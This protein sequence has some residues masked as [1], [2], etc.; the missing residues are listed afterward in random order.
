MLLLYS[1]SYTYSPESPEFPSLVALQVDLSPPTVIGCQLGKGDHV[2]ESP[3]RTGAVCWFPYSPS[4]PYSYSYSSPSPSPS[5]SHEPEDSSW[6]LSVSV[7]AL[8][9][10]ALPEEF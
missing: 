10:P 8:S 2:D 4:E 3:P 7:P 1:S 9:P 5:P 6:P